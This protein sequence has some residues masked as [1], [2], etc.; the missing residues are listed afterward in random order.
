MTLRYFCT[1]KRHGLFFSFRE[2]IK[3]RNNKYVFPFHC[4]VPV[5][6]FGNDMMVLSEL[7]IGHQGNWWKTLRKNCFVLQILRGYIHD[8]P[9]SQFDKNESQD[10]Q[11]QAQST[12]KE[13]SDDVEKDVEEE[14]KE[15]TNK[16]E[17]TTS[18]LNETR[19]VSTY[20][21]W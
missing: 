19:K 5:P 7:A 16:L 10:N 13:I 1:P 14:L 8:L 11:Q 12:G 15:L 3:S 18:Q 9:A 2:I 17:K 21:V 20:C 6:A 4:P